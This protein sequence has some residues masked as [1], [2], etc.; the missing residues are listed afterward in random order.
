MKVLQSKEQLQEWLD[1]ANIDTALWG[2]GNAKRV[3]H[4]FDEL[5]AGEAC[6][7]D[8]PPLRLVDVVQII[9]RRGKQILLEAEQEL[10][11]GQIRFRNQPPSEKIK[12]GESYTD[13]ALRCFREEL[14][15]AETAVAFLP[16]T[17]TQIESATDSLSYPGLKT[18]Y[19][20]HMIEAKVEGLPNED[21]WRDNAAFDAGDPVKRHRWTWRYSR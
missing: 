5:L 8:N 15:V 1:A 12:A 10:K 17:Y 21:F 2:E 19:T 18:C 20:F 11:N 6:L 9:V 3:E 7:Q 14:G 16:H 4:L 13:A